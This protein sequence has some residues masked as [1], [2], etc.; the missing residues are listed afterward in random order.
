MTVQPSTLASMFPT[1]SFSPSD[2]SMPSIL[3]KTLWGV[4]MFMS[5]G[6]ISIIFI[7]RSLSDFTIRSNMLEPFFRAAPG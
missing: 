7:L 6:E 2:M 3:I 5:L 1:L 4:M